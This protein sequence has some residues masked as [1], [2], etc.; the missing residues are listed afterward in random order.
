MRE[1]QCH[2]TRVKTL[3]GARGAFRKSASSAHLLRCGH[4]IRNGREERSR[5][6]AVRLRQPHR[7][8]HGWGDRDAPGGVL[9]CDVQGMVSRGKEDDSGLHRFEWR[10]HPAGR[11]ASP[12]TRVFELEE[13]RRIVCWRGPVIR[14]ECE[15][16][17]QRAAAGQRRD[18]EIPGCGPPALPLRRGGDWENELCGSL[19]ENVCG[20]EAEVVRSASTEGSGGEGEGAPERPVRGH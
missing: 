2:P 12:R 16:G 3:A 18:A 20:N 5:A 10:E 1:K 14:R 6:R 9:H 15:R 7:Y 8:S 13:Q 4:G 11:R 19:P 17:P